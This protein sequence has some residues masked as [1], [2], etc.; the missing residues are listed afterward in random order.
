MGRARAQGLRE[1]DEVVLRCLLRCGEMPEQGLID[2]LCGQAS[3]RARRH[4]ARAWRFYARVAREGSGVLRERI[5]QLGRAGLLEGETGKRRTLRASVEGRRA[6]NA[7]PPARKDPCQ[8]LAGRFYR[9]LALDMVSSTTDTRWLRTE[10][11]RLVYLA[12]YRQDERARAELAR[13]AVTALRGRGWH[14]HVDVI[15]PVPPSGSRAWLDLACD[16]AVRI[17]AALHIR[18]EVQALRRER[19]GV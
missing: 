14:E 15:V 16:A 19:E 4:M 17:G 11:G 13:R 9:G 18:T 1:L 6:L 8:L 5:E 12:K 2:V 7:G 3:L 10:V